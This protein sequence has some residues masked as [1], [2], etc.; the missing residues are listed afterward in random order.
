[1]KKILSF[2]LLLSSVAVLNV[3]AQIGFKY[4]GHTYQNGD[5]FVVVLAPDAEHCNSVSFVNQGY[6]VLQNVTVTMTPIE[7]EGIDI[8]GLCAGAYCR[9]DSVS[10]AFNIPPSGEYTEFTMDLTIDEVPQP[11]SIYKMK[12]SNDNV[13]C[14]VTIR[15]QAYAEGI[16][17]VASS[18]LTAY[19]NPAQGNVNISYD[20][21]QP[22]TL[23]IYDMQGRVVRNLS[24]SGSGNAV[25]DNLPAGIYT[26]GIVGSGSV[27]KLI[28]K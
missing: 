18:T 11:Y 22:S 7:M 28:V 27:Q 9:Q 5:E 23:A 20:V 16:N 14:S 1:M 26:Y 6:S 12:V 10:D 19:P 21:N 24:V 2:L 15:F 13:A 17:D 3:Q 4:N 25:V 8:W